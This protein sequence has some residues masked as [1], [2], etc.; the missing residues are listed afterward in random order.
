MVKKLP[1]LRE[2][3]RRDNNAAVVAAAAR[4]LTRK[5]ISAL[6]GT[7]NYCKWYIL[8]MNEFSV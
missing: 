8:D 2:I 3:L 6:L 7:L 1:I 4:K 5:Q